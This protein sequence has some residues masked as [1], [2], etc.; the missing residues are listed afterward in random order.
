MQVALLAGGNAWSAS[1]L[2]S[3]GQASRRRLKS[4]ITTPER[5]FLVDQTF[6]PWSSCQHRYPP[7]GSC[8]SQLQERRHLRSGKDDIF[9]NP[10]HTG[11]GLKQQTKDQFIR[12]FMSTSKLIKGRWESPEE[13]G[14][15]HGKMWFNKFR[16]TRN[17]YSIDQL[18]NPVR[19]HLTVTTRPE[20]RSEDRQLSVIGYNG[21]WRILLIERADK[22]LELDIGVLVG[23]HYR[24]HSEVIKHSIVSRFG[25]E[26]YNQWRDLANSEVGSLKALAQA[27]GSQTKHVAWSYICSD[28]SARLCEK[29][30]IK[31]YRG[32]AFLFPDSYPNK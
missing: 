24:F 20:S 12:N 27:V 28:S 23:T 31:T 5:D 21:I 25:Q 18:L 13:A 16:G 22:S 4:N 19:K 6:P 29:V 7:A 1:Y 8:H 14:R 30:G 26:V 32:T 11:F 3:R 15:F 9:S 10:M 17:D 2:L